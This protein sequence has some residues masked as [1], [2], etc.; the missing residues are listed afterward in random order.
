MKNKKKTF[1]ICE[2]KGADHVCSKW[3]ADQSLCFRYTDSK[4]P[5]LSK[6]KTSSLWPS[7]VLV[8]FGLC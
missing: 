8:Q 6:S 4:I 2:S 7:S 3:E 1:C 5:L